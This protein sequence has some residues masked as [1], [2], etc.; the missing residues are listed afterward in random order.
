MANRW[1]KNH[2]QLMM[3]VEYQEG[4]VRSAAERLMTRLSVHY[5]KADYVPTEEDIVKKLFALDPEINRLITANGA[6]AAAEILIKKNHD[7]RGEYKNF[8][9]GGRLPG[10]TTIA[11]VEKYLTST[12]Q[13]AP[14]E[15]YTME[16]YTRRM[17]R[18][19]AKVVQR[20]IQ[21]TVARGM[22]FNRARVES[23]K[24]LSRLFSEEQKKNLDM[25]KIFPNV[26]T[27]IRTES[28]KI[29]GAE[30]WK[31]GVEFEVWGYTYNAVGD[32]RTRESH[33]AQDGATAAITDPFWDVWTPPNGY[34]CRCWLTP[35][36]TEPN[37][38]KQPDR[39]LQPDKGF[40]FN[41]AT[42]PS[43]S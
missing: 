36:F 38:Y 37:S 32:S 2:F 24:E 9:E 21:D 3:L 19:M 5:Q 33:Q 29:I 4:V 15:S 31:S 41:P 16:A 7:L 23:Q 11:L 6:V 34:N 12:G 1:L 28:Q 18:E 35:R 14:M 10:K 40:A 25:A 39:S 27:V 17:T 43:F 42:F 20:H 8:F 13:A 22:S 26:E 30:A